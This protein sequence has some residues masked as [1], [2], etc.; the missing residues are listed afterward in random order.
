MAAVN[1]WEALAVCYFSTC[2]RVFIR[3]GFG[4]VSVFWIEADKVDAI[5][6]PDGVLPVVWDCPRLADAWV[7]QDIG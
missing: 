2:N 1:D 5:D 6:P 7:Q 4:R 3:M